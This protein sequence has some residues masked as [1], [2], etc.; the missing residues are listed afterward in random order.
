MQ[1][2]EFTTHITDPK[3][4]ITI[5]TCSRTYWYRRRLWALEYQWPRLRCGRF[6]PHRFLS[7][8]P[9]RYTDAQCKAP[10]SVRVWSNKHIHFIKYQTKQLQT[11]DLKSIINV[12]VMI[13]LEIIT[14]WYSDYAGMTLM[15]WVIPACVVA[16]HWAWP[17]NHVEIISEKA[18]YCMFLSLL[19]SF[20]CCNYV[21][22][23]AGLGITAFAMCVRFVQIPAAFFC[24]RFGLLGYLMTNIILSP[25]IK[26][27]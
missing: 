16:S 3:A 17:C 5:R 11:R 8:P 13:Y 23:T 21:I 4:R 27:L 18:T 2:S 19:S 15:A 9:P 1:L 10:W 7:S 25:N 22:I 20:S 24:Y 14:E 6:R 12:K 26:S